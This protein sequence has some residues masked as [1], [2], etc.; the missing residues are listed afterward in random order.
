MSEEA[1]VQLTE[2]RLLE[3]PNLYFSRP[4]VKVSL[5]LPGYQALD[6]AS[7]SA[8]AAVVGLRR[9]IPGKPGSEQRQRFL[10]RLAGTVLRRIADTVPS[11]VGVRGRVGT[12]L[13]SVIVAFPWRHR[14][15]AV[16]LGEELGPVL[17]GLLAGDSAEELLA[18]A[19]ARVRAAPDTSRPAQLRP[20]I[21]VA[22]VTGTN[23]KTSTTRMIE[24]L[25][26]E[27]GLTTGRLTSP[28]LHDLRE[29]ISIAGEPIDQQ[30]FLA[31]YDDVLPY[32]QMVDEQSVAQGGPRITYFELLVIIAYAVFSDA[33]VDVAVVE[34]GLGG[35]WDAT[36]VADGTVSVVAPVAIDHT[37]LLGDTLIDIATAKAGIIKPEAIAVARASRSRPVSRARAGIASDCWVNVPLGQGGSRHRRRRLRHH[38]CTACPLA[39]K[40]LTRTTGRSLTRLVNTPHAGQA[41]S[42]SRCSMTTRRSS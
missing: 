21:P 39:S 18:G 27:L 4:A 38:S 20:R 16:S 15:R 3:G 14:G 30:R 23:G 7:A 12:D 5:A 35:V 34:V 36:N 8:I 26:R 28:H 32:V 24:R 13:N 22:S 19:A 9:A 17:A 41:A 42:L 25:L 11:R 1:A 29:R 6:A 40:S 37:R 33:P 2:V 31:A 10:S